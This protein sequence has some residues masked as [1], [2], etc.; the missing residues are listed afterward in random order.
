MYKN[1]TFQQLLKRLSTF[2]I[3]EGT[4][5]FQL[6]QVIR[7]SMIIKYASEKVIFDIKDLSTGFFI[8]LSGA[9]RIQVHEL[10]TL[11]L[12]PGRYFG[13]YSL[14]EN[15]P[16]HSKATAL[17]DSEILVIPSDVFNN[18][19]QQSLPFS[20]N[21]LKTLV[22]R[23][24]SKERL[25]YALIEKN[26]MINQQ[27]EKINEQNRKITD[28][29]EYAGMIQKALLPPEKLFKLK[30]D[31]CF[32]IFRPYEKVSGDFFWFAQRYNEYCVA[33]ADCTGHG[34]PAGLISI[35]GITHLNEI[36]HSM[37]DP[38]PGKIL[39]ILNN[40][41]TG[42]FSDNEELIHTNEG[43]DIAFITINFETMKLRFAGANNPVYIVRNKEIIELQPIKSA[44]G[45][46]YKKSNFTTT[47]IPLQNNDM[48]Y[49]F[50][51]GIVD[52]L[53]GP[54]GKRLGFTQFK[55]LITDTSQLN[56]YNQQRMIL[57]FLEKWS[58]NNPQIDDITILGIQI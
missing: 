38:D 20:N 6:E 43:M 23:L 14:V 46:Q 27:N 4:Q 41:V 36:V 29:M 8:I 52:Q 10:K 54:K 40:K 19:L 5:G 12:G 37:Q 9:V 22:K 3:F 31:S 35:M 7:S 44:L 2:P 39:T 55:K 30:F 42:S 51:D 34:V 50:T 1:E 28:S 21:L 26:G 49:L 45:N 53:G 15:R 17:T 47:T 24:K 56:V 13:E 58:G 48:I 33:L 11:D 16:H 57:D 32:M 18:L 25:E